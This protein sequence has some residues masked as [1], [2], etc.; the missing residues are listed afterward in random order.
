MEG[1]EL[2]EPTESV[3]LG[4]PVWLVTSTPAPTM[5]GKQAHEV[6]FDQETGIMLFMRSENRYLGFEEIALNEPTPKEVFT[7]TGPVEER[8]IGVC[9]VSP[10][11]DDPSCLASW[12]VQGA[13]GWH[14]VRD[15]RFRSKAEAMRWAEEHAVE[16]VSRNN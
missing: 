3:E 5:E 10:N 14:Y 1:W 8:R 2:P 11:R 15:E 9:Y 7:W 13:A 6:A 4:R 16:V 12:Q